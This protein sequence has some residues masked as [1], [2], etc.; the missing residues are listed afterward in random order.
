MDQEKESSPSETEGSE[1]TLEQSESPTEVTD[2]EPLEAPVTVRTGQPLDASAA[3]AITRKG[4][5]IVVLLAGP[6]ASG[7]TT[8]I[9][10][11][12]DAF[13][14]DPYSDYD[15][16]G[17]LTL[18]AFE[19]RGFYA[20]IISGLPK[21]DTE[22]TRPGPGPQFLHLELRHRSDGS[23]ADLLLSD[24]PGETFERLR[25]NSAEWAH[26]PF[27]QRADRFVIVLDGERLISNEERHTTVY[28]A[29]QLLRS[30]LE[31][32]AVAEVNVDII[33]SKWDLVAVSGDEAIASAD[34]AS[35][36]ILTVV[37]Q[38]SERIFRTAA[39]SDHPSSVPSRFGVDTLLQSWLTQQFPQALKPVGP[40]EILP[41]REFSRFGRK[42]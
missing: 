16:R 23:L 40:Q 10:S 33:I 24:L 13:Q 39:R 18:P 41:N 19:E 37:G 36:E 8:L 7:K 22:R 17:S 25:D 20:R 6:V 11:L 31:S 26:L 27:V 9:V 28:S 1:T 15:F 4:R 3:Q 34:A 14:Q 21:P 12:Y 38:S 5:S 32:G 2:S 30:A 35:N 42:A 29:R